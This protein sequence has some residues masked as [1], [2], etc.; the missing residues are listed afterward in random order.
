MGLEKL[1]HYDKENFIG[2]EA[3]LKER[4]AGPKRMLVGLDIDWNE[5]EELFDRMGLAPQTPATASRVHVPVYKGSEQV[6]K[7]TST[8]WSPTAETVDRSGQRGIAS[9]AFPGR[10]CKSR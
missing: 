1:V 4:K 3:L 7:A 8:T 5:V 9:R 6:G 10:G 2:R